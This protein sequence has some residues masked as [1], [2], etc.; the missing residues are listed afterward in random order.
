MVKF[1]IGIY[2]ELQ[3]NIGDESY[4]SAI[5]EFKPHCIL[6]DYH[7]DTQIG[8][9][10]LEPIRNEV[11][12]PIIMLTNEVDPLVIINCMKS[13]ASDYLIKDKLT[14]ERILKTIAILIEKYDL[15]ARVKAL[16]SFLP[17]CSLCKKIRKK[18]AEPKNQDSWVQME[19]YISEKTG[20]RFS[21]GYCPECAAIEIE[22]VRKI[23]G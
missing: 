9:D 14:K 4:L 13:E 2:N 10:L 22:K 20:S 17:I 19:R 7:L 5:K 1:S 8:T 23:M 11:S 3:H 6:L 16:E 12:I 21:H 18:D 15:Q